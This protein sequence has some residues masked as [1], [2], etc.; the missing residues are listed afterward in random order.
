MVSMIGLML[1]LLVMVGFLVV[2]LGVV[3]VRDDPLVISW[4]GSG[5]SVLGGLSIRTI[6]CWMCAVLV[7][8]QAIESSRLLGP[9]FAPSSCVVVATLRGVFLTVCGLSGWVLIGYG[10]H[11]L[12]VAIVPAGV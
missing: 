6:P 12:L 7:V 11:L 9:S 4:L 2:L 3:S 1:D 8:K 5:H 10:V